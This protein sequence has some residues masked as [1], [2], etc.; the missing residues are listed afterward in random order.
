[1]ARSVPDLAL[2]YGVQ[3]GYDARA[4]LTL[5]GGPALERPLDLSRD[6][7]RARI[8]FSGDM[9]GYL[10]FEAGVLETCRAALAA[11]TQMGCS[12]EEANPDFPIDDVWRAWLVLRAWQAGSGLL[13]VYR[14]TSLRT[15]MK[16]EAI[17]EVE[18]GAKLSAYEV[19]AA[20]L[21][22]S[23]WYEAVRAFLERYDYWILPTAQVFPFDVSLD[24]PREIAGRRM[25]TYHEWMK[26]VLPV[27][28]SGC[29]VVT[30]PA[31][32]GANGLPMG[33]QIVGRNRAERDCLELAHA[34]DRRSGWVTKR[35]PTLLGV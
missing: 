23:R 34:Y 14:S 35:P 30:A 6:F 22:R 1:M 26:V 29:P 33:L 12:V 25:E 4:P 20:S 28:M 17:F 24:W 21:V 2:L 15:H 27:T 11:F 9:N 7:S 19:T 13:D 32:F 8:V 5:E 31:G 18:S 10:P 16:P 3:A